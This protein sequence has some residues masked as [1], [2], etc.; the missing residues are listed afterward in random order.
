VIAKH[1]DLAVGVKIRIGSIT[2]NHGIAA[3]DMASGVRLWRRH[4]ADGA[5]SRGPRRRGASTLAPRLYSSRTVSTEDERLIAEVII[6]AVSEPG[7]EESSS[8]SV[9]AAAALVV[10]RA[11]R[12]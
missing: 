5:L 10:H 4:S 9:T 7:I 6:P 1:S 11:S 2:A 8:T 12:I 3:L